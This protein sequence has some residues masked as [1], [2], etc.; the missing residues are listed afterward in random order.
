MCVKIAGMNLN[1]L[2]DMSKL[3]TL[4]KARSILSNQSH[5]LADEFVLLP[6]CQAHPANMPD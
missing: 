5:R 3:R 2:T 1:D 6:S 4:R